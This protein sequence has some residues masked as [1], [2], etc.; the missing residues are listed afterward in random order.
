MSTVRGST[1]DAK[2][3]L[4]SRTRC[5]GHQLLSAQAPVQVTHAEPND[6]SLPCAVVTSA[7]QQSWTWGRS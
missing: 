3:V 2:R 5:Q 4:E 1:L 6:Q 7:L